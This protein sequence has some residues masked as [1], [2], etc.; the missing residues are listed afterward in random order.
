MNQN[1]WSSK[2]QEAFLYLFALLLLSEWLRPLSSF[3]DTGSIKAF[4]FFIVVSFILYGYRAKWWLKV[5]IKLILILYVIHLWFYKGSFFSMKWLSSFIGNIGINVQLSFNQDWNHL[6]N[7]FRSLLF[8]LMLWIITYLLAYWLNI[9]KRIFVFYLMTIIYIALIDTF[10]KFDANGSIIR[11]LIIGFLLLGFL[12]YQRLTIKENI[13]IRT[14][15]LQKWIVP[16]LL[17]VSASFALALVAPKA[18][19]KWP[20]PVPYVQ[21]FFH[22]SNGSEFG[23]GKG[24]SKIGYGTDDTQLGGSFKGDS[25]IVFEAKTKTEHYWRIETKDVYTGKGWKNFQQSNEA[26]PFHVGEKVPFSLSESGSA[27]APLQESLKFKQTYTHVVYPYGIESFEAASNASFQYDPIKEKVTSIVDK[28]IVK[29]DQ[30]KVT[31]KEPKYS[32]TKLKKSTP[33]TL[34]QLDRTFI[35]QYTQLPSTLPKRVKDLAI[36]ISAQSETIYDKAKAIESYFQKEGF[37]YDQKNVPIPEKGVDY[38]DQ[39]LFDTQRGYCDNFSTSMIVMLR[40]IGIPARW[41]KGY[42]AGDYRRDGLNGTKVYEISNNNTHAWV[43]A[44]IPN[45]GWIP[46]EPTKGFSNNIAYDYDLGTNSGDTAT[47]PPV[48]EKPTKPVSTIKDE[49]QK[50]PIWF[51]ISSLWTKGK[52]TAVNHKWMTSLLIVFLLTMMVLMYVYRRRWFPYLLIMNYRFRK[53]DQ[54]FSRA[55][56]SMLKQLDRYG[57]KK[58][59]KQTLRTYARYIDT[60]FN[61]REMSKLTEQYERLLYRQE[62]PSQEWQQ[63]RELWENLIKRTTG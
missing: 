20:D 28:Q 35:D 10:T 32:L 30:Y 42:T 22:S 33:D 45:L 56:L 40:S 18:D 57:L 14:G 59:P 63:F 43:E 12:S 51:S 19:P 24:T 47:P 50:S 5:P 21:A 3:T 60:F 29:L 38:V 62:I 26:I 11:A 13:S 37:V 39:F 27:N 25:S 36:E 16:L 17:M 23:N 9:R 61:T 49:A 1:T 44:Y 7:E 46:F 6:S 34:T 53:S 52:E 58:D 54:T 8:F 15:S 48:K 55:Y 4:I 31:Y 41:V 2:I